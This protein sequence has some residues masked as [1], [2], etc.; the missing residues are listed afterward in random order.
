[1]EKETV[2]DYH[3]LNTRILGQIISSTF[4]FIYES[5][6]E[7]QSKWDGLTKQEIK[8][9]DEAAFIT[10]SYYSDVV[11]AYILQ[12]GMGFLTQKK[13]IEMMS[14]RRLINIL[15][16]VNKKLIWFFCAMQVKP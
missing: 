5:K 10:N 15:R 4:N 8:K 11:T 13:A 7:D 3:N 16:I 2:L 9:L 12:T 14:S 1:V 6:E